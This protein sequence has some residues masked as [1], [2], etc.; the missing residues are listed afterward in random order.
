MRQPPRVNESGTAAPSP[1]PPGKSRLPR[2]EALQRERFAELGKRL[3]ERRLTL[4]VAPAGAGKSTLL[5]QL[6]QSAGVPVAYCCADPSDQDPAVLL[7]RLGKAFAAALPGVDDEW[8]TAEE[9]ASSLSSRLASRALLL[10]DDFHV[11]RNSEAERMVEALVEH[12]PSELGVVIASRSRPGFDVSRLLVTDELIEVGPDDLRFRSWETERLFR[13]LYRDPLPPE[14]LAELTRRTEG[15][16]AGLKLF[17]LATKGKPPS[18]RRRTLSAIGSGSELVREYLTRNVLDELPEECRSFLIDTCV[19][20]R[21]SVPLCNEFLGRDDAE[22]ILRELRRRQMFLQPLG[23]GQ[24]RLH[25]VLRSC[26]EALLVERMESGELNDRYRRAG[27]RNCRDG[28][29]TQWQSSTATKI[30]PRSHRFETS[31]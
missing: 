12:A 17:H 13:D 10:I 16:A 24:F 1:V 11:L 26:L 18:L 23:D 27:Q 31:Q 2:G 29:S 28:R 4:I 20:G 8:V 22:G 25:D 14:Q 21:L 3:W 7:G 30:G 9:A 5:V 15:W 6:A 19:L